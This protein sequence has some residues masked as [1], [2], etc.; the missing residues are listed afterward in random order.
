MLWQAVRPT[1]TDGLDKPH[2][3]FDRIRV[4]LASGHAHEEMIMAMGL[5]QTGAPC[6]GCLDSI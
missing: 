1:V 5:E 4:K 2:H 3:S 6:R